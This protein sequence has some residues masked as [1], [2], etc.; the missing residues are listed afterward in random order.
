MCPE[1][2]LVFQCYGFDLKNDRESKSQ[3]KTKEKKGEFFEGLVF[4]LSDLRKFRY[5][6]DLL[7]MVFKIVI[8]L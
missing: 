7:L 8:S 6:T 1:K 2:T 3:E 4:P 5:D